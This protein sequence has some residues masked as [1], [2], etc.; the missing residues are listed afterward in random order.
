M[1]LQITVVRLEKENLIVGQRREYFLKFK[2]TIKIMSYH[3]YLKDTEFDI[4]IRFRQR[5]GDGNPQ[6]MIVRSRRDKSNGARFGVIK[7]ERFSGVNRFFHQFPHHHTANDEAYDEKRE[8]HEKHVN[9]A[10][11]GLGGS[12]G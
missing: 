11:N 1:N 7:V 3:A 2:M 10:E 8:E 5:Q 12:H 6:L 4:V 9:T